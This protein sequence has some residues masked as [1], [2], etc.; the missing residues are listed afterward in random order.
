MFHDELEG[1]EDEELL[2]LLVQSLWSLVYYH[3]SEEQVG[4][5]L[6]LLEERQLMGV[7]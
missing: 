6:V 1:V 4:Q 7:L 3:Q 5:L 2:S